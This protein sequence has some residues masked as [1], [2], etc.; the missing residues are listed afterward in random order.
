MPSE[1]I[2]LPFAKRPTGSAATKWG[3]ED[4]LVECL[5]A[6]QDP[7]TRELLELAADCGRTF[8]LRGLL[9]L[10]AEHGGTH[11]DRASLVL[12]FGLGKCVRMHGPIAS[13]ELLSVRAFLETFNRR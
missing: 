12:G 2:V 9:E 5:M 3:S 11:G 8:D 4:W 13:G 1:L 10:C 6:V 7:R